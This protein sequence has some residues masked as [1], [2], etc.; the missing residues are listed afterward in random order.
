MNIS[1]TGVLSSENDIGARA[2]RIN[3]FAQKCRQQ[4]VAGFELLIFQLVRTGAL[5]VDNQSLMVY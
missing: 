5:P 2:D 1:P 3:N 4:V